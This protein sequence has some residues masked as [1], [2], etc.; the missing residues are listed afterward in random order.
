MV[1][2]V[3]KNKM[4][5]VGVDIAR[6]LVALCRKKYALD[7]KAGLPRRRLIKAGRVEF[8]T[9]SATRLP[10]EDNVFDGAISFAVLHHI[11]SR[12]LRQKFFTELRRVLKSGGRA[13]IIVWNLRN[14]KYFQKFKI[15]EQLRKIPL[16]MEK[17]DVLIPWKATPGRT[18]MRCYH[19]FDAKELLSVARQAGFKTARVEF[20]NRAGKK[21]INGEDLVLTLKK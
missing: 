19:L 20:Y 11:P 12:E 18:V 5:Y 10:F 9:A 7:V 1:E 2:A 13:A 21:E 15:A 6:R 16:K 3:L 4:K 8:K 14:K 17:G